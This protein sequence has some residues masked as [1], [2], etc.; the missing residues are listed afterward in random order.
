MKGV[1]LAVIAAQ[2]GHADIRMVEKHYGHLAPNYVADKG[3]ATIIA[4]TTNNSTLRMSHSYWS[5]ASRSFDRKKL[6]TVFEVHGVVVVP[7][8]TP[9]KAFPLKDTNNLNWNLIVPY[10]FSFSA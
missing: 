6:W 1:P 9:Y 3:T 2:L 8:A 7:V 10:G 4:H 5:L